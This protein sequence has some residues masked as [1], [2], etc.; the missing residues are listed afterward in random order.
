VYDA[1][2]GT[3]RDDAGTIVRF[4]Y[5]KDKRLRFRMYSLDYFRRPRT[6]LSRSVPDT[7]EQLEEMFE[8]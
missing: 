5:G 6:R 3:V 2:T 1:A 7:L 4:F 8:L